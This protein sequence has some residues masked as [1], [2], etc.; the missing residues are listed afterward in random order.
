LCVF[1]SYGPARDEDAD[2]T[3]AGEI[4]AIYLVP[5]AWDA[6]IGRQLMAA[7]LGHL[8]RRGSGR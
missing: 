5:A 6:G 3:R 7:A 8:A 2:S 4:Y 1:V